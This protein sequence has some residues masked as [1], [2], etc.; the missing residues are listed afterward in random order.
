V[1][2]NIICLCPN[3]HAACDLGAIPLDFAK[4]PRMSGHQIDQRYVVYHNTKIYR[5]KS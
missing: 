5:G 2:G 1:A 3:H 4:L